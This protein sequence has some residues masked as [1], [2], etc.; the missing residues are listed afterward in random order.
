[1]KNTDIEKTKNK[2]LT[3]GIILGAFML[4][5]LLGPVDVIPDFIPVAG[6]AD[7]TIIMLIGMAAQIVNIIYGM[8]QKK[9]IEA[10]NEAE[11]MEEKYYEKG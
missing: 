10:L 2:T 4:G 3:I 7:D 9:K 6:G 8:E 5:Y 1:M 11:E